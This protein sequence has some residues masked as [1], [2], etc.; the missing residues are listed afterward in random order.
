MRPFI[1]P[2]FLFLLFH[3][4][5]NAQ[6]QLNTQLLGVFDRPTSDL[7]VFDGLQ[8]NDVW[9]YVSPG[10]MEIA[11][12]GN[13]QYNLFIDVTDPANPTELF[14]HSPGVREIW[15]DFKT[16]KSYAYGVCDE[17]SEGLAIYD[18]SDV[19]CSGTISHVRQVTSE[20]GSS[21]NIFIDEE[22]HRL[23]AVGVFEPIDMYVYDLFSDPLNPTLLAAID[24]TN[25]LQANLDFYVHDIFVRDNIAYCS[26]GWDGYYIWDLNDISNVGPISSGGTIELMASDDYNGYNHSSWVT[27][28]NQYAIVAE[29]VPQGLPLVTVDLSRLQAANNP[30]INDV[31]Q[32]SD[33]LEPFGRSTAHNPFIRGEYAFISYYEDGLKVYDYSI[34]SKPVLHAYYDTY[35]L[36]IGNYPGHTDFGAW[37]CYPFLP[38]GNI[39]VSD[40]TFGLHIISVTGTETCADGIQ[41][42]DETGIDC[43]GQFCRP[44]ANCSDGIQNQD[45]MGIDCGGSICCTPCAPTC[46]DGIQNQGETEIDCGGPNCAVCPTCF[47]GIQNQ[48][49]TGPDCGGIQCTPCDCT[50]I[51][52]IVSSDIITNTLE[53]YQS[54]VITIGQVTVDQPISASYY[55]GN[56]LVLSPQFEVKSGAEL[57]LSIDACQ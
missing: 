56:F 48:D 52:K 24:F 27:D 33:H 40:I 41:N 26:H 54:H 50:D 4:H 12:L 5:A 45:E 1:Y 38:S 13:S 17:C 43:G 7:P 16:Y 20:F 9:G 3:S 8:Y 6:D 2:L 29:E 21:H 42:Q 23:Y 25:V 30:M 18:M 47:D 39:L 31:E 10:G 15:R 22:N 34:P 14:R 53:R 37:G 55:A 49:E 57:L 46:D 11:I 28:D 32:F 36:N 35:P 19:D 44:C 51:S